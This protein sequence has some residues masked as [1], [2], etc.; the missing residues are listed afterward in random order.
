MSAKEHGIEEAD[1]LLV[2]AIRHS[3]SFSAETLRVDPI[4][5]PVPSTARAIRRRG[6]NFMVELTNRVGHME[7]LPVRNILR[8]NRAVRDQSVLNAR[9][10]FENLSGALSV[11]VRAG[12]GEA[13]FLIDDLIT[14]GSTVN[15]AERVLTIAGFKV[16]GAITACMAL[17]LR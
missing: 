2:N 10:R 5:I 1:D 9:A 11:C 16:L 17:P 7:D 4:L 8:H 12:R 13:V 6:R 3:L 15:E 14:T